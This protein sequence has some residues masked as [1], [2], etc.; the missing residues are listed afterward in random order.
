MLLASL[1]L[2]CLSV[3]ALQAAVLYVQNR[4]LRS[5][6]PLGTSLLDKMPPLETMERL[7]FQ[8]IGLGFVLLSVALCNAFLYLGKHLQ[9]YPHKLILAALTWL[10][11][12]FLLYRH[13]RF[14]FRGRKAIQ[15]TFLGL[16]LLTMVFLAARLSFFNH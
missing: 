8:V 1:S 9:I 4:L 12:A 6:S 13:Y 2:A 15:G 10:L 3:A 14:G 5:P 11:F 16:I 7:L